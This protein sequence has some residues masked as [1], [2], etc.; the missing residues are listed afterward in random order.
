M[1]GYGNRRVHHRRTDTHAIETK[2]RLQM[3]TWPGS[4]AASGPH[5]SVFPLQ[6]HPTRSRD[7]QHDTITHVTRRSDYEQLTRRKLSAPSRTSFAKYCATTRVLCAVTTVKAL[8]GN[9]QLP[10]QCYWV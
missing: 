9:L 2:V 10:C 8:H 7:E 4:G 3:G 5:I 1:P 6:R